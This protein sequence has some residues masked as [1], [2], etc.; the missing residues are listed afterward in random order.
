MI[1]CICLNNVMVTAVQFHKP[2]RCWSLNR[3]DRTGMETASSFSRSSLESSFPLP[4]AR[5]G[6]V[7]VDNACWGVIA[8]DAIPG[9][10]RLLMMK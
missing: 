10:I 3:D 5:T 6:A 7:V 9:K 8:M 4:R 2:H 1:A